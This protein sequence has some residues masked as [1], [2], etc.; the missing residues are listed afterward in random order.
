ME[1]ELQELIRQKLELISGAPGRGV[2]WGYLSYFL[3]PNL[4]GWQSHLSPTRTWPK[5]HLMR[6]AALV[7]L[8]PKH[9]EM[10]TLND[11]GAFF[12][13]LHSKHMPRVLQH[14]LCH[15]HAA[16]HTPLEILKIMYPACSPKQFLELGN[17]KQSIVLIVHIGIYFCGFIE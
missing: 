17:M 13:V 10:C 11:Q 3:W 8:N 16:G 9:S 4:M 14:S 1:A 6:R 5:L 2:G 7:P 15:G 12:A